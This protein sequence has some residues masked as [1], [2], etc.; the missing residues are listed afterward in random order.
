M[1]KGMIGCIALLTAAQF[2]GCSR[3]NHDGT[4]VANVKSGYSVAEDTIII[5]DNIITNRVGYRRILNG[6]L[7]SKEWNVKRWDFNGPD[8]PIIEWGD[9]QINIGSTIYKQIK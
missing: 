5:K 3:E 1:K 2:V 7:K 9:H 4:Y 8:A 6:H